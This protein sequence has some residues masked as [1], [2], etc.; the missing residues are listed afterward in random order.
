MRE[1]GLKAHYIKPYT[2][3]TRDCD[4]SS[5]LHNVLNRDFS[6]VKPNS[7]WCT[8]ITYIWTQN[9][10]LVYLTSVMDIYSRKIIAWKLSKTMMVGKSTRKLKRSEEQKKNR[11]SSSNSF[12]Q[13]SAIYVK[14]IL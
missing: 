5:R 6:P 12:R 4:F 13:R 2:T 1:N 11:Q 3:T 10:G 8:D 14:G 7:A 9:E